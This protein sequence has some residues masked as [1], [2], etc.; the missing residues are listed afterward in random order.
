MHQ[1]V[2]IL[3]NRKCVLDQ[4]FMAD[5]ACRWCKRIHVYSMKNNP[6]VM[7]QIHHVTVKQAYQIRGIAG[8]GL[9]AKKSGLRAEQSSVK[10]YNVGVKCTHKTHYRKTITVSQL[11]AGLLAACVVLLGFCR[12]QIIAHCHLNRDDMKW[13]GA[14]SS[15][16]NQLLS[17][18]SLI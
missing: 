3:Q 9:P 17:W 4:S 7:M 1:I 6:V 2:N 16:D 10:G 13:L 18:V 12:Q 15:S 11:L 5:T 14:I 8:S